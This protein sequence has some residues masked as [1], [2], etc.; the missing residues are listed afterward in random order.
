MG[1]FKQDDI[2]LYRTDITEI[3]IDKQNTEEP[4]GINSG[5]VEVRCF[6]NSYCPF[7]KILS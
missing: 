1:T 6:I 7:V 2:E 5:T 3:P 4:T